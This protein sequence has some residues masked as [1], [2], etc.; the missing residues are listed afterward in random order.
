LYYSSS[1]MSGFQ[2]TYF[3]PVVGPWANYLGELDLSFL[4]SKMISIADSTSKDN[5]EN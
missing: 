4:A 1:W 2:E 5:Y 3:S